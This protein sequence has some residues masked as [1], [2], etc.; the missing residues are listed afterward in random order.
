MIA[1]K[2]T[3]EGF[4]PLILGVTTSSWVYSLFRPGILG[5]HWCASICAASLAICLFAALETMHRHGGRLPLHLHRT[6]LIL[7][8]IFC[9]ANHAVMA[10]GT[11]PVPGEWIRGAA[12]ATA[13]FLESIPFSDSGCNAL[14]SA[15]LTGDRSSLDSGM[16]A[17]FRDAGAA[18]LLALSG[19]H[20][21][22]IYL[23]LEKVMG[24]AGNTPRRKVARSIATICITG[25]YTLACGASPSLVRAWLFITITQAGRIFGR[26]QPLTH[27]YCLALTVQLIVAPESI[28]STGFLLSY[29]AMA[30]ITFI[31]PT[32]REWYAYDGEKGGGIGKKIWD[33]ASLTIC[34]QLFTAPLSYWYFGT[35]PRLFLI[36]NLLAAPLL[37]VVM[38][39]GLSAALL[40]LA[41]IDL[42]WLYT[43]LEAPIRLFLWLIQT[44]A[45]LS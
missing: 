7:C 3:Y 31:W 35:F 4:V 15:L 38:T 26:P 42:P 14:L 39:S 6:L 29:L 19:M 11:G 13:R 40:W 22:I 21:G 17:A 33:A 30:G 16:K 37:S 28:H 36:T 10:G 2:T 32:V 18:H 20:L 41:G 34:C 43:L 24:I 1:G 8:G 27:S 5:A 23:I 44:I 9:Y 12:G 45:E 25:F